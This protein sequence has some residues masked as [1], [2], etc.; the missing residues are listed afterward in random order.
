MRRNER[1]ILATLGAQMMQIAKAM[2]DAAAEQKRIEQQLTAMRAECSLA[3]H[4]V[5]QLIQQRGDAV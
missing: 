5:R 3:R 4:V 1:D 2:Q